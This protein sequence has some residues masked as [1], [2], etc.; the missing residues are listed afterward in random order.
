MSYMLCQS[1]E[2]K[3]VITWTGDSFINFYSFLFCLFFTLSPLFI[4]HS[5]SCCLFSTRS[6]TLTSISRRAL[7]VGHTRLVL[8]RS[9]LHLETNRSP[10]PR[11]SHRPEK[12]RQPVR[13]CV[14]QLLRRRPWERLCLA[15]VQLLWD[16]GR[17]VIR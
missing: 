11:A 10:V 6:L 16:C 17:L 12:Q 9:G 8:V 3:T 15:F 4:F 5:L 7:L 1:P 13:A 2:N 14:V